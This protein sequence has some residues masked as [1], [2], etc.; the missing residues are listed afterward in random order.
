[1]RIRYTD[2]KNMPWTKRKCSNN[3]L[4]FDEKAKVVEKEKK[5]VGVIESAINL[6]EKFKKDHP[7]V[8]N[9]I[10]F[11]LKLNGLLIVTAAALIN[12][13][14]TSGLR[15]AQRLTKELSNESR[16]LGSIV[17]SIENE[18]SARTSFVVGILKT[19]VMAVEAFSSF[20][21]SK[22]LSINS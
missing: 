22:A 5:T 12:I 6:L 8:S 15:K 4:F 2:H 19:V 14:T 10:S 18:K 11:L 7:D 9:I 17:N 3:I 20:A 16:N 21:V 13:R 1:M